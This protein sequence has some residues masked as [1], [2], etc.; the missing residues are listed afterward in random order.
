MNCSAARRQTRHRGESS[1]AEGRKQGDEGERGSA[2][3]GN[4][5]LKEEIQRMAAKQDQLVTELT[6]MNELLMN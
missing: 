5:K 1:A 4:W 2:T 3:A 6:E